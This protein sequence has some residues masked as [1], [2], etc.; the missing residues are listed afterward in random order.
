MKPEV[1]VSKNCLTEMGVC[2]TIRVFGT[3]DACQKLGFIVVLIE[4]EL[5][6]FVCTKRDQGYTGVVVPYLELVRKV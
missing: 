6:M 4:I 1:L 3:C 2:F 5:V